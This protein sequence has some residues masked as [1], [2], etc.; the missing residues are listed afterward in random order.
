MATSLAPNQSPTNQSFLKASADQPTPGPWRE[1]APSIWN[2]AHTELIE[3]E[4]YRYVE[5]GKGYFCRNGDA[6]GDGFGLAGSI[7]PVDAR[8]LAAAHQM[9]EALDALIQQIS[10]REDDHGERFAPEILHACAVG[11]AAIR[12]ARGGQ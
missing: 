3:Q 5:G 12:K 6:T 4:N 7:R 1:Y 11:E 8:I 2:E 10:N 9:L